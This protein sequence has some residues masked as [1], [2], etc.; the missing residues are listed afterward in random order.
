MSVKIGRLQSVWALTENADAAAD[1]DDGRRRLD[2]DCALMTVVKAELLVRADRRLDIAVRGG[3]C[4]ILNRIVE[5][6]G[7]C[8][9]AG[10]QRID[11]CC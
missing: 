9:H 7:A 10:K 2:R 5:I 8:E 6:A 11:R 1:A 4:G 3:R